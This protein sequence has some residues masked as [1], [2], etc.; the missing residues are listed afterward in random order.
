MK[1]GE[2]AITIVTLCAIASTFFLYH[3]HTT[4]SSTSLDNSRFEKAASNLQTT[5]KSPDG[6]ATVISSENV[7]DSDSE[8]LSS[9]NSEVSTSSEPAAITIESVPL[10]EADELILKNKIHTL[11]NLSRSQNNL[12]AFTLDQKLSSLGT[13]RSIDMVEHNYFSH[14][15]SDGCDLACR[16]RKASYS[17]QSWGENLATTDD[18]HRYTL[19]E[20][21]SKFVTSWLKSSQHRDNILSD[22]FTHHG[23]G[24]AV[25]NDTIVITVLFAK[26]N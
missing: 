13:E 18:Y 17:A 12:P 5:I 2:L 6:V 1:L 7:P 23:I 25:E 11:T 15:S 14:V 4:L 19:D 20:L 3:N 8:S 26:P 9:E 16:F 24:I 21:A 22:K 10:S